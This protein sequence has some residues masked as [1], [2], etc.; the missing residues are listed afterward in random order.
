MPTTPPQHAFVDTTDYPPLLRLTL[1]SEPT[2][3]DITGLFDELYRWQKEVVVPYAWISNAA[4][5]LRADAVQRTIL[6]RHFRRIRHLPSLEMEIAHAV[7]VASPVVR[8]IL[9]AVEWVSPAPTRLNF[10]ATDDEAERFMA[11][12]LHEHKLA[13]GRV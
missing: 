13:R 2:V 8:G 12:T 4:R 6:A 3:H 1:P 11:V 5:L 10:F 9:T 7:I